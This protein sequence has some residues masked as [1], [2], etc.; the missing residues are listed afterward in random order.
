[1]ALR[2]RAASD[3]CLWWGQI[4]SVQNNRQGKLSLVLSNLVIILKWAKINV[5]IHIF[6]RLWAGDN[7]ISQA[8]SRKQKAPL[9]GNGLQVWG[10]LE[11]WGRGAVLE[12]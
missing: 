4:V 5:L 3:I 8:L 2:R 7:S 11:A 9:P 10:E 1:M 12:A 6:F